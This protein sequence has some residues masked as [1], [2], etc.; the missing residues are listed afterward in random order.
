[1]SAIS[2]VDVTLGDVTF[3]LSTSGEP[4]SLP[5][6]WLH[7]SGPG[8]TA[9]TNWHGALESLSRDFYNIA[10]DVIGFGDSTHPD[11]PPQGIAAFTTLRVQT[12]AALLDHLGIDTVDIIG[13]SMGGIV[14]LCLALAHS[15]R[16]R[17]IILMGA[18][19]APLAPTPGLLLLI[20]FYDNP[21]VEAMRALL[22]KFVA[23]PAVFGDQLDRIAAE[24]IPRATRPEVERSHRATFA[25]A[26][27]PLP[28][29]HTTLATITQPVLLIHGASDQ[30]IPVQA[31]TWYA[32][33]LPN[34]RLQIVDNAGHWLQI[35][36]PDVF[37]GLVHDFLT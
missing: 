23:D 19:G 37:A 22:P 7:G 18:G 2:T 9:L 11:P 29:N 20:L 10:P 8:V 15:Q 26:G 17:R 16:V 33:R 28:I 21:T 24:R 35:E 30:I 31:S 3:H 1:M 14:G 27:D 32:Q 5:V 36:H 6:L 25:R 4:G 34:A 13:N 12:L